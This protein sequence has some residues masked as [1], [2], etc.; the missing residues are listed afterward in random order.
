MDPAP[1]RPFPGLPPVF[2]SPCIPLSAS[3]ARLEAF[4]RP[5]LR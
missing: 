4:R 1:R 3:G 5:A 2:R